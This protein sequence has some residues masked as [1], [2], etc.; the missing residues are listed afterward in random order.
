MDDPQTFHNETYEDLAT[1]VMN[2]DPASAEFTTAVKNLKLFSEV[3]VPGRPKPSSPPEPTTLWEKTKKNVVRALDN[4][5]TRVLIKGLSSV[6]G[7]GIV[8][9]ATIRK[10]HVLERQA[11]D[12]ARQR[13]VQ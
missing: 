6:A 2:L 11:L 8:A 5:T 1:R 4:E 9:Y 10:D 13:P 3:T 12:Q 7:V